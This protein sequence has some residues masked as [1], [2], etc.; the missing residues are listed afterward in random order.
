MT[1]KRHDAAYFARVRESFSALRG[2][3][4]VEVNPRTT[5]LLLIHNLD[6]NAISDFARSK[7]LF[8]MTSA[9]PSEADPIPQQV[10][11]LQALDQEIRE[12]TGGAT[13]FW[14]VVFLTMFGIGMSEL[15]KGNI[16]APATS[17]LWYA[18]GA[19]LIA[20]GKEGAPG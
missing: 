16:A 8:E 10:F 15:I 2:I 7:S 9:G 3:Q 18:L 4:A 5:S 1:A 11:S 12:R 14:G 13:G 6:A 19:L 17:M 20:Q